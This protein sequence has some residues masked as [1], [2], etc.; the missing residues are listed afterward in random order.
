MSDETG[1]SRTTQ[2]LVA[3]LETSPGSGVYAVDDRMSVE[4]VTLGSDERLSRA[5][6][7]VRLDAEFDTAA[8][9]SRYAADHRVVVKTL[10]EDFGSEIAL[11]E[12]YPPVQEAGWSGGPGSGAE[13][14]GF[15]AR[16]VYEQLSRAR[17]SWIYGRR[18]RNGEIDDALQSKPAEWQGRSVLVEALPCA[19]NLDGANNCSPV[20][21]TV[22]LPDGSARAIHIFTYDDDPTGIPWTYAAAIR[23][24]VW[25][26]APRQGPVLEGNVFTVT[27]ALVSGTALVAGSEHLIERLLTRV[28]TLNCEATNLVESLMLLGESAGVHVTVDTIATGPSVRSQFRVWAAGDN[29]RRQL[30][31]VRGGQHADGTPR[32][33]ASSLSAADVFRANEVAAADIRWDCARIV[34][35]PIV[36]GGVKRYEMTVPLVPGWTPTAL[37]DN[38]SP[39][40]LVLAKETALL[41]EQVAELGAIVEQSPW[42]RRYHREGSEFAA[43][44]YVGR[45]WVL[46]EDGRFD[47]ATY[48]RN[49]P[50]DDYQ[51]FDFSTVTDDDIGRR[52]TWSRRSRVLEPTITRTELGARFGVLVEVSFDNGAT[53]HP[54]IGRVRVLASPT[55]VV[56]EV[57]NPT[58]VTPPGIDPLAQNMWYAIIDQTFRVRVTALVA[59]DDRLVAAPPVEDTV[60]PTLQTTSRIVDRSRDFKFALRAGTVNVLAA[61][62]PNAV[63]IE[64][65]DT[66]AIGRF[67]DSLRRSL[68][69]R[70]VIA[71]PVIPWLDT[72][73]AIG[74]EIEKVRGRGVSLT[75]REDG[76]TLGPVVVGKRYRFGGGR[77]ETELVLAHDEGGRG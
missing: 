64:V 34:N 69:D 3:M 44:R 54:P 63:D 66:D 62:N 65:D 10:E 25:F 56:F 61:T 48:N 72:A 29:E 26:Y 60:T 33:D 5:R 21:L 13:S 42:Y 52:G 8:A 75:T 53:W 11:F 17:R 22:T 41:P 76:R 12:G 45:R 27:D 31:L 70:R 38:V 35:A 58:E 71:S 68:Q 24:L 18:M 67:A 49:A 51:P 19:F 23:Y 55:G 32:F 28:D 36:L 57:V 39:S 20:P 37:L 9:R 74:D 40:D 59:G 7:S 6:I 77:W 30:H 15:T 47:G 46:N 43:N 50:F 16:S 73:F 14:F 2:T 4:E 1:R